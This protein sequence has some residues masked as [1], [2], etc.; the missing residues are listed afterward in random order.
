M[1]EGV[2]G[3]TTDDRFSRFVYSRTRQIVAITLISM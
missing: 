1:W 2:A 3:V